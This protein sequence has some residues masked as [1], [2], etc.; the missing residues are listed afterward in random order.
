MAQL[1]WRSERT[2]SGPNAPFELY[3]IAD[4]SIHLTAAG[5]YGVNLTAWDIESLRRA[6]AVAQAGTDLD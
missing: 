4:G 3:R 5:E 6:L 2:A 1:L